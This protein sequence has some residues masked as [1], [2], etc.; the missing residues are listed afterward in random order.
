MFRRPIRLSR[1][2]LPAALCLATASACDTE[3][4]GAEISPSDDLPLG[5]M[6]DDDMKAD[7]YW[8]WATTCKEIP[9]LP[10]LADPAITISIDGLTLHLVDRAG[11]YDQVFPIGAGAIDPSEGSLTQGESRSM[12]PVLH[13]GTG[14][15]SIDTTDTWSFDPCRIWWTS[16]ETGERLPVFAGLPFMRWSGSYG[17][18]GPITNYR[19]E[20][21]GYL[22]RGY[23]SHGCIRMEAADVVE[24]Y[25]LVK[26]VAQVPV[27]VQR[28]PERDASGRAEDVEPP[29]IGSE[30]AT[31]DD[32]S[33]DS[34][35][36]KAN[37][38]SGRKFCSIRCS[39]YCPDRTGYPTT[40]CVTDPDDTNQGFCTMKEESRN[41]EC[42]PYDHFTPLVQ[43]RFRDP[44][45]SANVCMP[46][47][48]RWIGDHCFTDADCLDGNHC[49]GQEGGAPGICT[50]ACQRYCPDAPGRPT[51][52]CV[53]EPSLGGSVCVR[54]CTPES[55]ASECPGASVCVQRGRA[56]QPSLV[57]D[58][59]LPE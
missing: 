40:F 19:A 57:R 30:C 24:V 28:E 41:Y 44:A 39:R 20:N 42:R 56:S 12:F 7:G 27:H 16:S 32:C 36:C 47:S 51:T 55:N 50:Q 46:G 53:N 2:L 6:S 58:V 4:P 15:F 59:C 5:D 22:E 13:F 23:V 33:F 11:D 45:A 21:G 31:D 3:E 38:Y 17:I 25:A 10:P 48:R 14:D 35:F 43:T 49:A 29:W 54:Q 18:H 9:Y 37:P 26:G 34:G 1:I 52:F 8:G